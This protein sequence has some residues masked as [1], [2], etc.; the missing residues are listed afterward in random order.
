MI[1]RIAPLVL[2]V[3]LAIASAPARA[4]PLALPSLPLLPGANDFTCRPPATHPRPVVLV[5][6]TGVNSLITWSLVAPALHARGYC[7][8]ALDHGNLGTGRIEDSARAL[9][10]FVDRV[11][12]ATGAATVDIIGHSSGGMMPRYYTRFLG[13][14]AKV[15][16]LIGVAPA[17]HG[18]TN[19]LFP[20]FG[21]LGCAACAQMVAGSPF[22]VK[23]NAGGDPLPG[24]AYTVISTRYDYVVTPYTSQALT[25]L[26]VTNVVLQDRC[27]LNLADHFF[28]TYNPVTL[29]WIQNALARGG[30]ANPSFRPAC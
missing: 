22:L 10:T 1:R 12:A 18:S 14:A 24:V 26:G 5:H 20:V 16:Q 19:P 21:L 27:P 4:T 17:N 2:A 23:L 28:I 9:R 29:Q 3:G 25:G 30:P 15:A 11:L 7:V 6:G 8:F 13:G